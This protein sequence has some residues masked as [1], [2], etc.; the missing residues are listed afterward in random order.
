MIHGDSQKL[1]TVIPTSSSYVYFCQLFITE[2]YYKTLNNNY[3]LGDS[4]V[5]NH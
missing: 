1:Y 5:E 4:D 2:L 3:Y